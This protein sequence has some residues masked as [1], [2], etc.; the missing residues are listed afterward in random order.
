MGRLVNTTSMTVDGVTDV[1]DWFVAQGEHDE[2][3]R[4]LFADGAALLTG[5]PTYEGFA[6]YWPSQ[7]GP[8]AEALNPIPKFVASRSE[9][10]ELEW[11][12]RAIEGDAIAGV[13]RLKQDYPGDLVLSG[14]GELARELIEAALVDELWFWI[15]PR[16]Q[17]PGTRPYQGATVPMRHIETRS[18]DSGVSLLRYEPLTRVALTDR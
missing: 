16:I 11:N 12:A 2:A 6:S 3:A 18:Y 4:A 5:R 9:L 15:H 17:G 1:S 14:C 13:K 10:R 7:S 8:W